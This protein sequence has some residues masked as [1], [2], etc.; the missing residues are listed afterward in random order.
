MISVLAG[1]ATANAGLGELPARD[2]PVLIARRLKPGTDPATLSVLDDD[3]WELT[4]AFF[5]D[6]TPSISVNFALIPA[7][8]R[9]MAKRYVWQLL[10]CPDPPVMR[11]V[12]GKRL[13]VRTIVTSFT[14]LTA[15]LL[16]LDAR[17]IDQI[18]DVTHADLDAYLARLLAAGHSRDAL[19]E[20]ITAVR[21]LWFW[22]DRLTSPDR[23][24]QTPPWQGEDSTAILG[25]RVRAAENRTPRIGAEV[26]D[27]LLLWSLRFIEDFGDDLI[28][29]RDEY[30]E[31]A[32]RS[33]SAR[34]GGHGTEIDR[35]ADAFKQE[36]ADLLKQLKATGAA[37]PGKPGPDGLIL[38][39]QHLGRI[40]NC[41]T[42]WL[43][44]RP[45]QAMISDS[46]L[47]VA[48][49]AYLS[50][51]ILGQLDGQP[52]RDRPITFFE[53]QPLLQHLFTAVFVTVSYLSGARPGEALTLRRGCVRHDPVTGLWL[54]HGRKW[55]GARDE[56]GAKQPEGE[57]RADPWVVVEAVAKAVA[58]LEHLHDDDL[59]F[60]TAVIDTPWAEGRAQDRI[61]KARTSPVMTKDI[62]RFIAWVNDYCQATGRDEQ[63]PPD[64]Q[65]RHLAPSRFRRTLAWHIVRRPRGL[66]AAA[67]QY[68]HVQVQLTLG[69]SGTYASG[70][71]DEHAFEAWLLRLEQL[72]DAEHRLRDG[73]HVSGPAARPY[74]ERVDQAKRRFAGRVLSTGRQVRDLLANPALQI[75]PGTGMTCVFDPAKAKCRLAKSDED[76]RRTPDLS[77]C[78]PG[79]QNI[80]RTDRDIEHVRQQIT[81]LLQIVDD[82]LCPAPRHEREHRELA[83][84]QTILDEHDNTRPEPENAT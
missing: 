23:L 6:H 57:E 17:D 43:K 26:M 16:W 10:N 70:F 32:S 52:W 30:V 49:D 51:R 20:R 13:A 40:L 45:V 78:R 21:R 46:G 3:R 71:P 59:L 7:G 66:V 50:A 9:A 28:A 55:K 65:G 81:E 15:F 54:L 1:T 73:E 12:S 37:L 14:G 42:H 18:R 34:L 29:V 82:P 74:L 39:R 83:R 53:A 19:R 69:Y 47:P 38:D 79:C 67:I 5:E 64:P 56:T 84:L 60:P 4:P 24:P 2:T 25:R 27:R 8:L 80:A 48:D 76:T 61:G 44:R 35:P 36:V 11:G 62:A 31:L 41:P 58:V 77:D 22:R 33:F 72:T 63:I 68:S 75:Y